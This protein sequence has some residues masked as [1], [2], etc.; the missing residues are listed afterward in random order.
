MDDKK[1]GSEDKPKIH[2][3]SDWK[4]EAQ[5]EK[6]RLAEGVEKKGAEP[7]QAPG[8]GKLP[9]ANFVFIVQSL[10]TQAMLFMS[11]ERDPRTG[12][13]FRDLELAKHNIDLL[14]M[15]DEKT[16]GNLS[17]DEKKAIDTGLYQVRMAYIAANG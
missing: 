10:A 3:D 9:P 11:E 14:E 7:G 13:S 1:S 4:A 2:V 6:E 16:K 5:A 12:R 8:R 15:L 17:E